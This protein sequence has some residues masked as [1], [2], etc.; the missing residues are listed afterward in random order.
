MQE[1]S[2]QVP[3]ARSG[4]R[5]RGPRR[6]VAFLIPWICTMPLFSMNT[7]AENPPAPVDVTGIETTEPSGGPGVVS[8][9]RAEIVVRDPLGRPVSPLVSGVVFASPTARIFG[10]LYPPAPGSP[11]FE[12]LA[13]DVGI[14]LIRFHRNASSM[15]ACFFLDTDKSVE[16]IRLIGKWYGNALVRDYAPE[17]W[18]TLDNIAAMARRIGAEMLMQVNCGTLWDEEQQRVRFFWDQPGT[19]QHESAPTGATR[20]AIETMARAA[21]DLVRYANIEKGYGIRY[22]EIGNEDYFLIHPQV[23]RC[24]VE[25]FARRMREVDPSIV[26]LATSLQKAYGPAVHRRLLPEGIT[27]GDW[28]RAMTEFGPQIDFLSGHMYAGPADPLKEP[29]SPE[30]L[31][32]QVLGDGAWGDGAV[33]GEGPLAPTAVTEYNMAPYGKN[34]FIF[35]HAHALFVASALNAFVRDCVPLATYHCATTGHWSLFWSVWEPSRT[36][37]IQPSEKERIRWRMTPAAYAMKLFNEHRGARLAKYGRVGNANY[38][39][40]DDDDRATLIYVNLQP[41]PVEVHFDARGVYRLAGP[42]RLTL[43]SGKLFFEKEYRALC[44][45]DEE[46]WDIATIDDVLRDHPERITRR[47]LA[48]SGDASFDVAIPAWNIAYVSLPLAEPPAESS[49]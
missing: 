41:E 8:V 7:S 10:D 24:I 3:A 21:A 20:R 44:K 32:R 6:A 12:E 17:R 30:S 49:P 16:A 4:R 23:Y 43:L 25:T 42:G 11:G 33:R 14:P 36:T 35:T 48:P 15:M 40:M 47:E 45:E 38:V 39:V 9:D 2:L 31:V 18:P 1:A 13:R 19:D 46:T 26:L 37:G 22:W 28:E 5:T 34:R 29:L 27:Y